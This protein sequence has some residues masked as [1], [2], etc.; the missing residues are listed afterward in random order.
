[1]RCYGKNELD[2]KLDA[3]MPA[4]KEVNCVIQKWKVPILSTSAVFKMQMID[5]G[6]RHAGYV[7]DWNTVSAYMKE[8][9]YLSKAEKS[10]WLMNGEEYKTLAECKEVLY[11]NPEMLAEMKATLI[12]ELIDKGGLE[13]TE[14]TGEIPVEE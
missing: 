7:E 10:G 13:A 3:V 5:A 2:K 4:F 1:V 12:R 9:D 14:A 11:G 6:G 8:L